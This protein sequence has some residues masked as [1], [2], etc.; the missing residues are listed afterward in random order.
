MDGPSLSSSFDSRKNFGLVVS[1]DGRDLYAFGMACIYHYDLAAG[2]AD[3]IGTP[4]RTGHRDGPAEQALLGLTP[5]ANR[6]QIAVDYNS[7]RVYFMSGVYK[8]DHRI[9]YVEKKGDGSHHVKTVPNFNKN[10]G[11]FL[12]VSHDGRH[13][14]LVHHGRGTLINTV[15]PET[16]RVVS[17]KRVYAGK[18]NLVKLNWHTNVAM[19][20]DGYIYIGSGG[21][22]G[23]N[24]MSLYRVD[25][26]T[27]KAVEILNT[28]RGPRGQMDTRKDREW[29]NK[30]LSGEVTAD[31]PVGNPYLF[32]RSTADISYCPRTGAIYYS[33][34]DGY[35]IRRYLDGYLTTLI[36]PAGDSSDPKR[37]QG[38][39]PNLGNKGHGMCDFSYS[40]MS[41][42]IAPDG[43][44]YMNSQWSVMRIFRTDWPNSR[45][46]SYEK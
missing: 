29:F 28:Y 40:S 34:W 33:G 15:N 17:T 18:K 9:R 43:D 16:G 13:V 26:E 39:R 42:G 22:C 20:T 7:G 11:R 45:K 32:C 19:G 36:S 37:F 46:K 38:L 41:L 1:P 8:K 23:G 6:G 5:S 30:I 44:I 25:P 12:L 10:L 24:G 3:I 4:Y 31:G 2:Q 35:G 14:Y 21:E 27:A